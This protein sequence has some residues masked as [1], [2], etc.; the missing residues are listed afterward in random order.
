MSHSY[1]TNYIS[2]KSV[3]IENTSWLPDKISNAKPLANI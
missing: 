1:V 2:E 3:I